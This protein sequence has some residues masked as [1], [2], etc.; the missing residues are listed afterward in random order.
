[1]QKTSSQLKQ[2]FSPRASLCLSRSPDAVALSAFPRPFV[3]SA[4]PVRSLLLG[5]PPAPLAS[6]SLS[7]LHNI[8]HLGPRRPR[9]P[10][11]PPPRRGTR[12]RTTKKKRLHSS[13]RR[14]MFRAHQLEQLLRAGRVPP[15]C[16]CV[17]NKERK[18]KK[19]RCREIMSGCARRSRWRT[20]R[21]RRR[22]RS[23]AAIDLLGLFRF[24]C[25]SAA[26]GFFYCARAHRQEDI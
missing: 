6:S 13:E 12:R 25:A 1:M 5:C 8:I 10:L 11:P 21:R 9:R 15:G 4:Y 20:R 14:E 7:S 2:L 26:A 18:K 19:E 16:A 22:R 24:L 3:I 23:E 17:Y